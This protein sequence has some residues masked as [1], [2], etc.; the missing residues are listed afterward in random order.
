MGGS[1]LLADV[2][3]DRSDHLC[4]TNNVA[5]PHESVYAVIERPNTNLIKRHF[6]KKYNSTVLP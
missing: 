2:R 1:N 5:I 3:L 4:A 6:N